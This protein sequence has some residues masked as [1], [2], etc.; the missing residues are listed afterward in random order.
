M[1]TASLKILG[2][3]LQDWVE[4]PTKNEGNMAFWPLTPKSSLFSVTPHIL[5]ECLLCVFNFEIMAM[6][7][8]PT[9]GKGFARSLK[10]CTGISF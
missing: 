3:R 9:L 5:K 4:E 7:N 2:T 6:V 8:A 1:G 10:V